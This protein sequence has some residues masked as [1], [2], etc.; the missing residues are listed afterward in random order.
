MTGFSSERIRSYWNRINELLKAFIG[1]KILYCNHC[2]IPLSCTFSTIRRLL[3]FSLSNLLESPDVS[4]TL[5]SLDD[6]SPTTLAFFK[7]LI[8][9]PFWFYDF[10]LSD[11][12]KLQEGLDQQLLQK[13][14]FVLRTR[15]RRTLLWDLVR[16]QSLKVL[17]EIWRWRDSKETT[18]SRDTYFFEPVNFPSGSVLPLPLQPPTPIPCQWFS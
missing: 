16:D 12:S 6:P 14:L 7:D 11:E 17:L 4:I 3:S 13:L 8:W 1:N 2:L 9:S 15:H 18:T 5:P 10:K